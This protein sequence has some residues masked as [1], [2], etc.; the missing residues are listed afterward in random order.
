[1]HYF[2]KVIE[3]SYWE[4]VFNRLV[5]YNIDGEYDFDKGEGF[6]DYWYYENSPWDNIDE[7]S[8]EFEDF[9]EEWVNELEEDIDGT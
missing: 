8:S 7:Y 1:M 5:N 3:K 9:I 4:T 2:R 6:W